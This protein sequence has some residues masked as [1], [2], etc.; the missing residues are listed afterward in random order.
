M[1]EQRVEVRFEAVSSSGTGHLKNASREGL[2]VVTPD[3]PAIGDRTHLLFQDLAYRW[4][5]LHGVVRWRRDESESSP[6]SQPG[7]AV[8]LE[9]PSDAYLQFFEELGRRP[10]AP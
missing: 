9:A 10:A 4:I 2:F 5:E 3:P 8:E 1:V 6:T 7:F